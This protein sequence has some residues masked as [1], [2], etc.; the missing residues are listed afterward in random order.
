MALVRFVTH[1]IPA[2]R[3]SLDDGRAALDASL[4]EADVWLGQEVLEWTRVL[5]GWRGFTA[6]V[7]DDK[8]RQREQAVLTRNHT[9]SQTGQILLRSGSHRWSYVTGVRAHSKASGVGFYALDVHMPLRANLRHP[10]LLARYVRAVRSLAAFVRDIPQP[11][12]IGGD[13]NQRPDSRLLRPL[14]KVG[15][16]VVSPGP[17][18]GFAK[19]QPAPIDFFLVRGAR[20][21]DSTVLP[22]RVGDHAPARIVVDI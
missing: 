22:R 13:W 7:P 6:W 17:T 15:F 12:V 9:I 14:R 20:V 4:N 18:H 3:I 8:P 5:R 2:Q 19:P 1:N 11:V 10:V 16:R 21:V